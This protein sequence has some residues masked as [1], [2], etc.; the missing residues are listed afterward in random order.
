M[1][2]DQHKRNDA[3]A[4]TAIYQP[5]LTLQDIGDKYGISKQRVDQILKQMGIDR[6]TVLLRE[7][8]R[9]REFKEA[10]RAATIR[11]KTTLPDGRHTPEYTAY[12]NMLNR[13]RKESCPAY[14]GWGGRGIT[15]CDRWLGDFGFETFLQDMKLRPTDTYPSGRAK[16]SLHRIDN[17]G[18][19][20]PGNCEWADQKK[21]CANRRKPNRTSEGGPMPDVY[22]TKTTGQQAYL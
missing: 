5:E 9:D 20:Q 4:Y 13:C 22:R 16:Y 17:D 19:Y 14:P 15:V 6:A 10:L 12:R 2:K 11:C 8:Q 1:R 3:I 18:H 21:Q 7:R